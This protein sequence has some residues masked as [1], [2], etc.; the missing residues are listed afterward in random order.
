MSIEDFDVLVVGLGPG[1]GAAAAAAAAAGLQVIAIDRKREIGTPVQCAE[2]IPLPLSRHAQGR[3]VLA[4]RITAMKSVLPSGAVAATPFTGLMVDRAAFDRALA[5]SA[6]AAGAVVYTASLLTAL[7]PG[8]RIAEIRGAAGARRVRYRVLIAADGPH[9]TV[10]RLLGLPLLT[11]VN[12]R[13]YTVP[14]LRPFSDTDIWLSPDY[15]GGYAWLFPKGDRANLGLG[16]DAHIDADMKTPL[17]ALHATLVAEG[18][19]GAQILGRTGGA[20]PVGGLRERLALAEI[21][22]V[23]DAAGMTHPIT[24]AGIAAGVAS[25]EAAA[26]AARAY[27]AGDAGALAEYEEDMRDQLGE[28]LARAVARRAELAR[29]WNTAAANDDAIHRRG[30]IAFD[31]YYQP[32]DQAAAPD[33]RYYENIN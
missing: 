25:G 16:M 8:Q 6:V 29:V 26:E 1:G 31:D 30:W 32:D 5:Q 23:G 21:L 9:S 20:I 14:L 33:R 12:T 3:S 17:D 19:V 15:P 13:Q 11:T 4:Q 22:L 2:F 28:S 27:V 7:D 18:R 10:A 24:G